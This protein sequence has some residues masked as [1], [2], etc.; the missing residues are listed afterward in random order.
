VNSLGA[1]VLELLSVGVV[2]AGLLA[3]AAYLGRSHISHWL[4]KDMELLKMRYQAE[5]QVAKAGH[6]RDLETYKVSL[7]AETERHKAVQAV[8]TAAAIKIIEKKHAAIDRLHSASNGIAS[9]MLSLLTYIHPDADERHKQLIKATE[10][11]KELR[12]ARVNVEV[13]LSNEDYE[14]MMEF[15]SSLS[16]AHTRATEIDKAMVGAELGPFF[17]PLMELRTTVTRI[18]REHLNAIAEM[19]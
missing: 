14:T 18:I 5:L 8:K 19:R 2:A 12:N 15:T 6:E 13:F 10:A 3:V 9:D 16:R 1:F 7:I 4:N 11:L 17:E